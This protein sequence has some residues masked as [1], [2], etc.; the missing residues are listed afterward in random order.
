MYLG[1]KPFYG[2]AGVDDNRAQRFRSSRINVALSVRS[3]PE[4]FS[5]HC[6]DIAAAS[7]ATNAAASV[8][9]ALISPCKDRPCCLAMVLSLLTIF[10]S[11]F[12]TNMLDMATLHFPIC[13][14][15]DSM[16]CVV[17]SSCWS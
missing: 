3:R 4:S 12:L 15:N 8:K 7:V 17:L 6:R 11:K 10:V 13:Y 2:N 5:C 1:K 14:Q 16:N 9:M